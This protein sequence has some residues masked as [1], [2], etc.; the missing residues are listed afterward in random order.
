[1]VNWNLRASKRFK[2]IYDQILEDSYSGA[3]K[4]RSEIN[5]VIDDLPSD[6]EIYPPD[7][8]KKNNPGNYRA[9]EKHSYR[10]AY[11]H[12]EKEIRILR[13]RHVKQEPKEY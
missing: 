2:K 3:Q 4:V 10:V 12:T 6:P 9:F 5:A 13:I 11:R 8:Y 1:M 7:K